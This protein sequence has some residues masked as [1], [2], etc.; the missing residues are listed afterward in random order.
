MTDFS[1]NLSYAFS[2]RTKHGESRSISPCTPPA[3]TRNDCSV[4]FRMLMHVTLWNDSAGKLT[5]VTTT[6]ELSAGSVRRESPARSAPLGS[7]NVSTSKSSSWLLNITE[8]EAGIAESK[9]VQRF[10]NTKYA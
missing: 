1:A 7:R 8:V 5:L 9:R 2:N 4:P 6:G 10:L 3:D